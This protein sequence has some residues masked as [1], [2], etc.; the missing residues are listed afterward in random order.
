VA[1]C[2]LDPGDGTAGDSLVIKLGAGFDTSNSMMIPINYAAPSTAALHCS[3]DAGNT[4]TITSAR[5][6]AVETQ[7]LTVTP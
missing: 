6:V 5:I 4:F 7:S 1:T 2:T 3:A